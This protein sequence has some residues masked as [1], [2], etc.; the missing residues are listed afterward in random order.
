MFLKSFIGK[1]NTWLKRKDE[2]G[3]E[4]EN[5]PDADLPE[6]L[7][8]SLKKNLSYIKDTFES[9]DLKEHAFLFGENCEYSG[10]IIYIDGL[11]NSQMITE[12]ILQPLLLNKH[13][14]MAKT[15]GVKDAIGMVA[16]AVLCTGE[17]VE[18]KSLPDMIDGCLNGDTILLIEG[19]NR[20]L[21][22]GTKGW[23]KRSV[24]EP[25]SEQVIRGPREGF[26]ENFRTNTALIRRR[27]KHPDL[28]MEHMKI[29]QRT[30]TNICVAYIKGIANPQVVETVRKRLL[31]IDTDSILD[32]GYIEQYIED[33][34]LSVFSTVGYT[35]KPDVVAGKVL[36]G[37]VAIVVEGSPFILTV[38]MLF[39][40]S[41]QSAEDYYVRPFYASISR[42]MRFIAYALSLFT[43]PAF[44]ALTS[45]HQELIPTTLLFTIARAKEGTPFPAFLE[46]IIMVY[47]FEILRE[48]GLR[49]PV[50]V[51]QA[52]SIVGALI[53]GD[54]AVA[55]GLVGAP[56]VIAVALSAVAGFVVPS[57]VDSLS[58]LRLI[59]I[60]LAATLGGFGIA[61]GFLGIMVHLSTLKSFG[62]TYFA[63]VIPSRN[64]QDSFI[65]M[66]LWSMIKRP[67]AIAY[68]DV[69]RRGEVVP[70]LTPPNP[71]DPEGNVR[72]K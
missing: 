69:K 26:T 55:A 5:A 35:E 36:E 57:Q 34:P 72:L 45:Y 59:M 23:E 2:K 46:A 1:I 64:Q 44:I 4:Q 28:R 7:D 15:A 62:V 58:V 30:C 10:A 54:A 27:I 19:V 21:V 38:P 61:M 32:S 56:T 40:E 52:I 22:I 37:R 18:S 20:G 42:L 47:S 48:A 39:I 31:S 9:G 14:S 63:A 11:V 49:L 65:R 33:A 67:R 60:I 8:K 51:G 3:D 50:P 16:K 17:V 6:Q 66:P 53:M 41:F 13:I 70:P 12:G 25:Q 24:A 71:H 29:G 68:G 43:V